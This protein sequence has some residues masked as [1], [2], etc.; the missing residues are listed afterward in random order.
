MPRS[1]KRNLQG[2]GHNPAM[3]W[4]E[5][6]LE[7][8]YETIRQRGPAADAARTMWAFERARAVGR[9]DGALLQHLLAATVALVA[10]EED[11]TPRTVLEQMFRRSVSDTEWS[12]SFAP[13]LS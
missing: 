3:D 7:P 5:I 4:A 13:L 1:W 12:E 9:V 8:L 11:T 10:A 2:V 6:D